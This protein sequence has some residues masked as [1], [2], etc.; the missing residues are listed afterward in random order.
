MLWTRGGSLAAFPRDVEAGS[1]HFASGFSAML[2]NYPSS[3]LHLLI[4]V[5]GCCVCIIN[6]AS[7]F[8]NFPAFGAGI[9]WGTKALLEEIAKVEILRWRTGSLMTGRGP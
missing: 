6:G 2:C 7:C 9:N 4:V 8:S 1:C 5:D 3:L